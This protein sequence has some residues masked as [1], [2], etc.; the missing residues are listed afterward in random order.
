ELIIQLQAHSYPEKFSDVKITG[1]WNRFSFNKAEPMQPQLDGTFIFKKKIAADTLA[2]QLVNAT[3]DGHTVNGTMY[4][5]LKYDGGGDYISIIRNINGNVTVVFDP[6]KIIRPNSQI[7]TGVKVDQKNQALQTYIDI[8]LGFYNVLEKAL[9]RMNQPPAARS[10]ETEYLPQADSLKAF[11][12]RT[13]NQQQDPQAARFAAFYL[14]QLSKLDVNIPDSLLQKVVDLVPLNDPFWELDP[15][16]APVIY[17]KVLGEDKAYALFEK[18]VQQLPYNNVRAALLVQ[19]GFK[20]KA[21]GQKEKLSQIY[22]ELKS[23]HNNISELQYYIDQLNPNLKITKGQPIPDFT[24]KLMDSDQTIS[25]KALLGKY[26]I[27]DFWATWCRP[28]VGEMAYLHTAFANYKKKNFTILS[29]SFDRNEDDVR[30]FRKKSW[31]MPWLH[32]YLTNRE[33]DMVSK[34]FEIRGIP[35]PILV[36]PKG[37]ILAMDEELRGENLYVTLEKYIK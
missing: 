22:Q 18:E 36:S 13:M 7:H 8:S 6:K 35:R 27:I 23:H 17:S 20:A 19:M 9:T 29:L 24:F 16:S 33:R 32:V 34:E 21:D 5:A 10:P 12:L 31:K 14:P 4:D 37:I 3:D 30:Q 11:L 25:K 28:C 15:M 26:Y 1:D 2:Y